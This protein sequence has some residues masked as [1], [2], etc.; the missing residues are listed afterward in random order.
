MPSL[1]ENGYCE[2]SFRAEVGLKSP[3]PRRTVREAFKTHR[4]MIAQGCQIPKRRFPPGFGSSL[5]G[6]GSDLKAESFPVSQHNN[7]NGLADFQRFNRVSVIVD[8]LDT[9]PG[10][11][12]NDIATT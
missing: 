12:N 11:L 5:T 9:A 2:V 4:A 7:S 6:T 1:L 10:Q 3:Y 8:I